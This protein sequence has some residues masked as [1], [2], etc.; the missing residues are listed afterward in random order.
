LSQSPNSSWISAIENKTGQRPRSHGLSLASLPVDGKPGLGTLEAY[1]ELLGNKK[2]AQTL[3]EQLA[4]ERCAFRK[5][6]ANAADER[7]K[8]PPIFYH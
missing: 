2:V 8:L 3:K 1:K 7:R 6:S 5:G 4:E